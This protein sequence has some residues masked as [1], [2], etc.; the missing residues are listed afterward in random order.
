MKFS[1]GV[2]LS[3]PHKG[4][5]FCTKPTNFSLEQHKYPIK[6]WVYKASK[7]SEIQNENCVGDPLCQH[8]PFCRCNLRLFEDT[9][10]VL[11][12]YAVL[13]PRDKF[14]VLLLGSLEKCNEH[15]INSQM[16][17]AMP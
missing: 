11:R 17:C 12:F 9:D 7:I 3:R 4:V 2:D 5:I 15:L 16:S 8:L 6:I 1:T 13:P 14:D 10:E